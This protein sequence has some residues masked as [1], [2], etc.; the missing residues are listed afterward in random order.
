MELKAFR[1]ACGHIRV[2][3]KLTLHPED[4]QQLYCDFCK[5][6]RIVIGTLTVKNQTLQFP[7]VTTECYN[8]QKDSLVMTFSNGYVAHLTDVSMT[9]LVNQWETQNTYPGGFF[10]FYK[11]MQLKMTTD[12]RTAPKEAWTKGCLVNQ[13]RQDIDDFLRTGKTIFLL[14]AGCCLTIL[15]IQRSGKD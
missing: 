4:P 14:D 13:C 3:D 15:Y 6:N 10:A 1:L 7:N 11:A 12:K 2:A 5:D 8:I 9:D